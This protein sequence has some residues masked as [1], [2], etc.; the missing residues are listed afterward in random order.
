[1]PVCHSSFTSFFCLLSF[2]VKKAETYLLLYTLYNEK[3]TFFV[4]IQ[5]N[6]QILYINH[7][8]VLSIQNKH[9]P[10]TKFKVLLPFPVG[11]QPYYAIFYINW[12]TYTTYLA[13]AHIRD[14]FMLFWLNQTVYHVVLAM[15]WFISNNLFFRVICLKIGLQYPWFVF[16]SL[17]KNSFGNWTTLVVLCVSE[18]F[19]RNGF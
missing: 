10:N 19:R 16:D 3:T 6:I 18:F 11:W 13:F 8:Y 4:H 2:R 15:C 7:L 5:Y 9:L 1:M 14:I 17:K 12:F